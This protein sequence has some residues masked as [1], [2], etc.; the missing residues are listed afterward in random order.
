LTSAGRRIRLDRRIVVLRRL[1]RRCCI[2]R[3]SRRSE[4]PGFGGVPVRG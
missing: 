4:P 2:V 1:D 3:T